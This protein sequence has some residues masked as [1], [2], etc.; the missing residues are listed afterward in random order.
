MPLQRRW[1]VIMW[2]SVNEL[3][4]YLILFITYDDLYYQK[5][6][7][8]NVLNNSCKLDGFENEMTH[9]EMIDNGLCALS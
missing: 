8:I 7:L 3:V 5:T 6:Y 9:M 2:L 4:L 1:F